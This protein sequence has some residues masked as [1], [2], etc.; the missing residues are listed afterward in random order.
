MD[1][2]YIAG[3]ILAGGQ[4]RRMNGQAKG[5]I[6]IGR[7]SIIERLINEF[8]QAGINDL[9][10]VTN[11]ARSYDTCGLP[12]IPDLRPGIGPLAGIEAGLNYY[13]QRARL[14]NCTRGTGR[15]RL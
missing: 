8:H 2:S 13:Q 12:V 6:R 14:W 7:L 5:H 4:A 15:G 3:V 10:L 11:N 9:I 1:P